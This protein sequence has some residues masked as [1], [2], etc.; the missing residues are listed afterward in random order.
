M[1]FPLRQFPLP[2]ELVE[3]VVSH[4]CHDIASLRVAILICRAFVP[5]CRTHLYEKITL[6]DV[7]DDPGL[8]SG[9]SY[10]PSL[11]EYPVFTEQSFL[12]LLKETPSLG[13]LVK[14]VRISGS[15]TSIKEESYVESKELP[16]ILPLLPSLAS[17]SFQRIRPGPWIRQGCVVRQFQPHM[18]MTSQLASL[19]SNQWSF[20]TSSFIM[21]P[22]LTISSAI[23]IV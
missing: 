11:A 18:L 14:E 1:V 17:I 5:V 4:I 10:Y 16:I 6:L 19:A 22:S 8:R 2:P 7:I 3:L 12:G 21:K 9:L 13:Q 23:A 20:V 15:T